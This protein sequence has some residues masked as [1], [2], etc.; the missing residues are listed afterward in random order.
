MPTAIQMPSPPRRNRAVD[1][2]HRRSVADV[3]CAV[4]NCRRHRGWSP[5]CLLLSLALATPGAALAQ[6]GDGWELVGHLGMMQ[7]VIVDHERESE[8]ALYDDAI[9]TLCPPLT[10]CFLRFYSNPQD[11]EISVPLPD[12]ISNNT[13]AF[14]TLSTK[15]SKKIFRWSCRIE[16][17]PNNCY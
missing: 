1:G 3:A 7:L 12:E 5:S 4:N 6:A 16:N 14:Y 8:E 9:A 17:D 2:G 11:V 15:H 10:T 13:A